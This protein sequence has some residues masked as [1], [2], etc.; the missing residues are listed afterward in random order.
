MTRDRD[1][2]LRQA[3]WLD[4]IV[5]GA[6]GALL[7]A[8]A[9]PLTGLLGLPRPLLGGAGLVCL[10]YGAGLVLL[11][12]R[13]R[14]PRGAVTAV[15]AGNGLWVAASLWLLVS[16]LVAPTPLGQGFVLFQATAVA[17][18]AVLQWI[19]LSRIVGATMAA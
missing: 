9:G 18:F 11:A 13:T 12:R 15:V 19:G 10:A 17:G 4:A 5:S 16:G 7:W 6:T 1:A 14:I 3:L 2:L 8:G